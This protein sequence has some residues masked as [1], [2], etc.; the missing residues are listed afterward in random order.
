VNDPF[1]SLTDD[2]VRQI[3]LI[4]ESLDRST[5][6]YLQLEFGDVKLTIGKGPAPP[7]LGAT[8]DAPA[9]AAA[10]PQAPV[11][12]IATPQ[13]P[14]AAP[15]A[16]PSTP[17]GTAHPP[18]PAAKSENASGIVDVVAPLLGRFYAQPEPGAS[19]VSVGS[20]VTEESTV[21]LIEVMKTFNA[22]PAGVRGTITEICVQDAQFIEYGQVLCRV[23]TTA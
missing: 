16:V 22:V 18:V 13:P 5:F 19:F 14:A 23:R 20:E 17:P 4:I 10:V 6:D 15:A 3:G 7:V 12:P 1:G 2:E 21:G 8:Q 9:A 11:F